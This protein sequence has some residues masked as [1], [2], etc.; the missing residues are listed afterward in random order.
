MR[1]TEKEKLELKQEQMITL[2]IKKSIVSLIDQERSRFST[3][4]S[5][6]IIQAAVERLERLGY[7][8]K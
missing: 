6:W 5:S 1:L 7:E 2:R 4:R 3:P 8:T